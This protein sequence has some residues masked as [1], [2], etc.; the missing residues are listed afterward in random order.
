MDVKE[1]GRYEIETAIGKGAA[2]MVYRAWD[3]EYNRHIA[4]KFAYKGKGHFI[5]EQGLLG[6]LVH[7]NIVTLYKIESILD[8]SYVA[9]EYATGRDLR[10]FCVKGGLLKPQKVLEV[11]IEALKGLFYGHGKGFIHRN[12]KPSNIILDENLAAKITDYGIAQ[13]SGKGHQPGFWG[14]PDYMSPE[15]LRGGAITIQSDIFSMGC[16]LYEMLEGKNP[17][18]G[19]NQYSTISNII[20]ERHPRLT[21]GLPCRDALEMIIDRALSKTPDARYPGCQEF[22]I[23]LSKALGLLNRQEQMGKTSILRSISDRVN[24]LKSF[25]SSARGSIAD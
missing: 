2:G 3:R 15:Q 25:N 23:D 9:M 7:R 10:A 19:E 6:N 12:L 17:F 1:T 21:D 4:I 11:M 5:A 14:V 13:M 22:A 16:I 8:V 18:T 20:K 24:V